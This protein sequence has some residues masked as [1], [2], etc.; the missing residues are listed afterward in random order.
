MAL[1]ATRASR[2]DNV[3]RHPI[4]NCIIPDSNVEIVF[5]TART[6]SK[7]MKEQLKL[8]LKQAGRLALGTAGVTVACM[9]LVTLCID[10]SLLIEPLTRL[11]GESS[12]YHTLL[13]VTSMAIGANGA[14]RLFQAGKDTKE[15]GTA[16]HDMMMA[17]RRRNLMNP[18]QGKLDTYHKFLR[19][20]GGAMGRA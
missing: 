15:M 9:S 13:N 17:R 16:F 3:Y 1:E 20:Q 8:M 19:Q 12:T 6:S 4:H 10:P 11:L 7:A 14:W 5:I 18:S 2:G